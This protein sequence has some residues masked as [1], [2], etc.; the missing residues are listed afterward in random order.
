MN[1]SCGD[2]LLVF[3]DRHKAAK[4]GTVSQ[5]EGGRR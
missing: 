2:K 3:E 5:G 4:A 1:I